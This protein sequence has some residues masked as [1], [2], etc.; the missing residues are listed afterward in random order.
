VSEEKVA[1]VLDDLRSPGVVMK[2]PELQNLDSP[3]LSEESS[4]DED[5]EG[6]VPTSTGAAVSNDSVDVSPKGGVDAT[7]A[8]TSIADALGEVDLKEE[9]KSPDAT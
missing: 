6:G 2:S 5:V 8:T 7:D 4:S 9:K 1:A 3:E